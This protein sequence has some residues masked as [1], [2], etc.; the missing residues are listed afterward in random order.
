MMS[1]SG[2]PH[3]LLR[4]TRGPAG[5]AG[6]MC[7]AGVADLLIH[8]L[9][10]RMDEVTLHRLIAAVTP[11]VLCLACGALTGLPPALVTGAMAL[12]AATGLLMS[13][14]M[15]TSVPLAREAEPTTALS[16]T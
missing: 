9:R 14:L 6:W 2:Q 4:P 1:D 13:H 11:S 7:V 10:G 8:R 3:A 15:V 12:A 16:R 5:T